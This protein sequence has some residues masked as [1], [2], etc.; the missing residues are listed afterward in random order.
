MHDR[1]TERRRSFVGSVFRS[2]F[3]PVPDV[4][5]AG[6]G[7]NGLMLACELGLAGIRPVLLDKSPGPNTQRRA[8]GIVGQGV[9]LFDHRG[10][11]NTL[12]GTTEPP[13]PAPGS[14]FAGFGF[15]FAGIAHHQLYTLRVEQPRLI[16][17]LV[18]AAQNYDVD[19]RWGHAL[20][21]FEHVD[22][23]VVVYVAGPDGPYELSAEYLVGAD[24]GSS[25]TRKLAG[26]GFPGMSSY[27]VT[28]HVSFGVLPPLDWIDSDTGALH[29]PG[30]G[31]IPPRQYF[32]ADRG[33]FGWGL[34][35]TDRAGAF[36]I[37]L[38]KSP[39]ENPDTS[40]DDSPPS[41]ALQEASIER[42]LGVPVPLHLECED[43]PA[44]LRRYRGVNSRIASRYRVGRVML[45]GD[46]AHVQPPLGG[47]GLNLGLQ[48]AVNVGW[49]LAAVLDGRVG[50]ELLDTYELE[51][52]P[53]AERVL[54][55][56]RAQLALIRPGA[57]VSALR[58]LF[59]ELLALPEVVQHL[60][61]LVSGADV[62]YGAGSADHPLVGRWVPDS[63]V[64]DSC[65]TTRF[66]ELA[67]TGKPL[68][69]DLTELG[70]MAAAATAIADRIVVVAGR[71]VGELS[72]TALLVRPDGY[73]AWASSSQTPDLDELD[74]ALTSWF[75]VGMKSS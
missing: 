36:T 45:V 51:R 52:R 16:E 54:M 44:D 14:F 9:R 34:K 5:I 1:A 22:D 21:G 65:G 72:A 38:D 24:G 19:F 57:E 55:H 68:L 3:R 56:S 18:A 2:K 25:L 53:A 20:S 33:I 59:G 46:A 27:D 70:S 30:F 42:V 23:G 74:R 66:A 61:D 41:I 49:K 13:Q 58:E 73:V 17:V 7:P 4:V 11:Y 47:P 43:M 15:S 60:G 50:D 6:G 75:G 69:I 40:G 8:A 35:L 63:A 29:V 71:P 31:A 39:S 64:A 37:E 67:R 10:L 26:I 62:C 48:D 28:E 12:A 32:R